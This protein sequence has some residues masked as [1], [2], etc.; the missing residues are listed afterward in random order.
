MRSATAPADG[1]RPRP[2]LTVLLGDEAFSRCASWPTAPSSLPGQLVPY[3]SDADIERIVLRPAEPQGRGI[4]PPLLRRC[5][6]TGR[7]R[8]ATATASTSLAATS[9]PRAATSTTSSRAARAARRATATAA[10][11]ALA[12]NRIPALRNPNRPRTLSSHRSPSTTVTTVRPVGH[13][14]G[15]TLPPSGRRA[16]PTTTGRRLNMRVRHLQHG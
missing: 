12:H 2:L 1:L 13:D 7:S 3:L 4:P 15:R 9:A 5:P 11:C 8:C 10:Y 14:L 16:P 6:Q